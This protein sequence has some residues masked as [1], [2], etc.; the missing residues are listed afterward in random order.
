MITLKSHKRTI[1]IGYYHL[2]YLNTVLYF[3]FKIM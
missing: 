3:G 2:F 1:M